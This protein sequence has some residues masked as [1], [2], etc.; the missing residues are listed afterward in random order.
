MRIGIDATAL[1]PHPVGAGNYI[2]ELI[3]HLERLNEA[4]EFVIFAQPHGRDLIDVPA[5]PGFEWVMIPQRSPAQRLIWEQTGFPRLVARSSLDLLHSLH[6]TRPMRLPCTSVVTFHD[7]TFFL[8]PHLHTPSKRLYFP[9]AIRLSARKANALIAV[10]ESTRQDAI[11]LLGIP[12]ARIHTVP[13]GVSPAFHPVREASLLEAVRQRYSLPEH[14]ILY[15]G[16]VEP[17]KNL[18]MLLRAYQR[19]P[20]N[21]APALVIVGRFG[22]GVEQVFKLVESLAIRDKVHFSGYIPAEDLPIVYNLADVFVYPSL[23]EGFGLPP[24]EAMAC[25]TPVITTSVSS[26]PEHVGEA[27]ILVPP[28]DEEAL[29]QALVKILQDPDLR[30]EL[31]RKGP[32]RA[33]QYSWNRT[34]QETLD[35][36]RQ[37]QSRKAL[38]NPS[39]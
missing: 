34:A 22:W 23:Y 3:R 26:L 20:D 17:R 5:R 28:Q 6:Y 25:G 35:V 2:I 36:Y 33:A 16:L 8:F 29:F 32:E 27:G 13:L 4:D 39:R 19:L 7:M 38:P 21:S 11:R 1:P 30:G 10:S 24:L 14:F 12:P 37:V 31:S 15:V 18:P 9:Q